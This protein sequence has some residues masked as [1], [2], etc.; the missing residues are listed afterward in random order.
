MVKLVKKA[1]RFAKKVVKYIPKLIKKSISFAKKAVKYIQK[2]FTKIVN[3]KNIIKGIKLSLY[4]Y[5]IITWPKYM[6][7]KL[8]RN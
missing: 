1:F 2:I 8:L 5:T 3:K 7:I 6:L 4:I